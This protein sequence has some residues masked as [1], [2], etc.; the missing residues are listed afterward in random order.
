MTDT[1]KLKEIILKKGIKMTYLAEQLNLSN[2]GFYN[3]LNNKTN[4]YGHEIQKLCEILN[5]DSS[6]MGEIFFN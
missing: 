5:I 6:K 2:Q 3:K 4:F 1:E